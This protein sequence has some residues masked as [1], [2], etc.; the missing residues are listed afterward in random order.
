MQTLRSIR[1]EQRS[2]GQIKTKTE[3]TTPYRTLFNNGCTDD[4]SPFG[5]DTSVTR[6]SLRPFSWM[7]T[8]S[9]WLCW[10]GGLLV[11][12][13][14]YNVIDNMNIKNEQAKRERVLWLFTGVRSR[15]WSILC[16]T[17]QWTGSELLTV[18]CSFNQD[19]IMGSSCGAFSVGYAGNI[20]EWFCGRIGRE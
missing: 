19:S 10:T 4:V 8:H 11:I 6:P 2:P 3:S 9:S 14:M 16:S 5:N 1:S 18:H 12:R 20:S 13:W 7:N 15:L 17:K